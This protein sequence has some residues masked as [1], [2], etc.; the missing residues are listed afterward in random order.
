MK[1]QST[2]AART[3]L[4]ILYIHTRGGEH[5]ILFFPQQHISSPHIYSSFFLQHFRWLTHTYSLADTRDFLSLARVQ[6]AAKTIDIVVKLKAPPEF[7]YFAVEQRET[8]VES[9]A[10]SRRARGSRRAALRAFLVSSSFHFTRLF[11]LSYS[12]HIHIK[13]QHTARTYR[14]AV[15]HGA[16]AQRCISASTAA[17]SAFLRPTS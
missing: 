10:G 2:L 17:A 8:R 6:Q 4:H 13:P 12:P 11:S 3:F 14:S 16:R 5:N 7:S 9:R 1:K 15:L